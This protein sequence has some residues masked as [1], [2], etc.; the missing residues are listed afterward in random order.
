LVHAI[1]FRTRLGKPEKFHFLISGEL[2]TGL[3]Q[4]GGR[5][6]EQEQNRLA[7]VGSSEYS[8]VVLIEA[9][10]HGGIGSDNAVSCSEVHPALEDSLGVS[11]RHRHSGLLSLP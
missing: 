4:R 10:R 3:G 8:Q 2:E 1:E 9:L 7:R 6:L 11:A 5:L